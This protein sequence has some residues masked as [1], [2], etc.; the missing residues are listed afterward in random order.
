MFN[1]KE[2]SMYDMVNALEMAFD[3]EPPEPPMP[4]SRFSPFYNIKIQLASDAVAD[5]VLEAIANTGAAIPR[6]EE[7]A[8]RNAITNIYNHN[9]GRMDAIWQDE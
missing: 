3:E 5:R 2:K 6:K 1:Y 7:I 4:P 9:S 8:L